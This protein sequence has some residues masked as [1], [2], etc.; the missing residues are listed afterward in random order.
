MRLNVAL[1]KHKALLSVIL[2]CIGKD[3]LYTEGNIH[4]LDCGELHFQ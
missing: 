3:L 4:I 2:N 1:Y